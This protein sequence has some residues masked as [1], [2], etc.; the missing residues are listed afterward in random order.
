MVLTCEW[1]EFLTGQS[2]DVHGMES[3]QRELVAASA[4]E[5]PSIAG[6]GIPACSS[7]THPEFRSDRRPRMAVVAHLGGAIFIEPLLLGHP[8]SPSSSP[9]VVA[10][11]GTSTRCRV[12]P[13]GQRP[14]SYRS[15]RP[16]SEKALRQ[17]VSHTMQS[18]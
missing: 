8:T 5:D 10:P 13:I 2:G 12:P 3:E 16:S 9:P 15:G 6:I 18:R 14:I 4:F 7:H 1:P 11:T 17:T